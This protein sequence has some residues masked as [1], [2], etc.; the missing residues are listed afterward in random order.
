MR[1]AKLRRS[2]IRT[3]LG[4]APLTLLAVLVATPWST[5]AQ[6]ASPTP[7]VLASPPA[8]VD[9]GTNPNTAPAGTTTTFTIVSDDSEAAYHAKEE[10]AGKGANT[11]IGKTNAI[12]GNI[13]FGKNDMPLA[14]SRFDVDL[15][16]LKSDES[17]RDNFLYKNTL[18]TQQYPLATFILTS[19]E[20]LDKPLAKGDKTTFTLI[21]NLTVH[22]V[23]KLVAWEATAT[24]DGDT[25]KGSA[26]TTFEMPDFNITPPKVGPVISLSQTVK[27]VVD[28]SAKRASS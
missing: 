6:E 7:G 4:L 14:C 27:L 26:T 20:G 28:I 16:T 19:V 9:C 17:R 22:G 18:E 2:V 10:L 12:I 8:T 23:T 1:V 15:R 11:A 3:I 21:G 25:L 24:A 13:Y 5:A